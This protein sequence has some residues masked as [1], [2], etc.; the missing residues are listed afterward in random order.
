M[1]C[2]TEDQ[3]STLQQIECFLRKVAVMTPQ[4]LENNGMELHEIAGVLADNLD[5]ILLGSNGDPQPEI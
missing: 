2:L 5:D 3:V 4:D 1:D